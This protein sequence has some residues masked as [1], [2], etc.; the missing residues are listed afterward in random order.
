MY[1]HENPVRCLI[2]L[3]IKTE[4]L[5]CFT[6]SETIW[7]Y[8]SLP[9]LLHSRYLGLLD[10]PKHAPGLVPLPRSFPLECSFLKNMYEAYLIILFCLNAISLERPLTTLY[11][12]LILLSLGP[13]TWTYFSILISRHFDMHMCLLIGLWFF[14]PTKFKLLKNRDFFFLF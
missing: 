9:C 6:H 1:F 11:K 5:F 3:R 10:N 4:V 13:L 12:I 2:S 8:G 14:L 7:L